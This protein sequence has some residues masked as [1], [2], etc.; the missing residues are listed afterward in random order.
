MSEKKNSPDHSVATKKLKK[1]WSTVLKEQVTELDPEINQLI[2]S[3]F[4]AIRFC[5]PTQL[6]G[7]L[8]D[9]SLNCLCLQKGSGQD[10]SLWDPR[11]FA[12]KVIVPWVSEI[13]NILGTSTDPYVS[14]PLRKPFLDPNPNNVKGKDEWSLLYKILSEVESRGSVEYTKEKLI[15]T[16]RCVYNKFKDATFE[17]YIPERI[18][19]EQILFLVNTYL[20]EGSGGDRGLSVAAALFET[21]GAFFHIY[22]QV[23]RHV[24]NASDQATG[25]AGDIECLDENGEIKLIVEVKERNLSLNDVRSSILKARKITLKELLFN[26]PGINVSEEKQITELM[27][28]TWASGTH[29]YNLTI[30]DLIKVGLTLTGEI[31]RNYFIERV[32]FQLDFY[33]TQPVNR[34]RWKE[35]LEEI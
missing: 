10:K 8:T 28:R 9:N 4:V 31:G 12:T 29:V 24:I 3:D 18:S 22:N 7:K 26:A 20:S 6:L 14:K 25:L 2:N 21:F 11:G 35:L 33:N 30:Q 16:L 5:L 15:Q 27:A 19:T 34:I 23:N 17:Y 32:C 13:H 1:L